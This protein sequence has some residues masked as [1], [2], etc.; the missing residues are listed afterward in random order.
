MSK[1]PKTFVG[2]VPYI[3]TPPP[4]T[5]PVCAECGGIIDDYVE[6]SPVKICQCGEPMSDIV[7]RLRMGVDWADDTTQAEKLMD[8]AAD[9]IERQAAEIKRRRNEAIKDQGEWLEAQ[10]EIE[11]LR[12][13][14]AAY[15]KDLSGAIAKIEGIESE[16][17]GRQEPQS[18][19][20]A[21]S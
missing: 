18:G 13:E 3:G 10:A 21:K 16:L 20:P 14:I 7:E 11:R 2:G 15:D 8:D 4:P 1:K 5:P 17:N 12:E 6:N 19:D 9:L